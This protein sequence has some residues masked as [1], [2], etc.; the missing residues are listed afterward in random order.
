MSSNIKKPEARARA[1]NDRS[2]VAGVDGRLIWCR[3]LSDLI[4]LYEN[5]LGSDLPEPRRSIVRRAA[6]LT[7]ELERLESK[8]ATAPDGATPQQLDAYQRG[9]NSLRRLLESNGLD[10]VAKPINHFDFSPE[11]DESLQRI[12]RAPPAV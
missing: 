12:M 9:A 3:R 8:F 11:G 7:I 2:I 10:R 1:T 5:E 6:T 4:A